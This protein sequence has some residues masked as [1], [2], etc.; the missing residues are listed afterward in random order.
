MNNA[1]FFTPVQVRF[2]DMDA[3]GHL[4]NAVY[5]TYLEMCRVA[6]WRD[7]FG[8]ESTRTFDVIIGEIRLRYL[9]PLELQE[10]TVLVVMGC[11]RLGN[12][13]FDMAY[14]IRSKDHQKVFAQAVTTQ[15]GFDY[16]AQKSAPLGDV[17]R[18]H[19]TQDTWTPAWL[20]P[21]KA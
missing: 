4:N 12:K 11:S 14:E 19:L 5:V 9:L 16:T 17:F 15:V 13:S 20:N 18:H 1:P 8:P 3:M 6:Y 10:E 2:R 7:R 21:A